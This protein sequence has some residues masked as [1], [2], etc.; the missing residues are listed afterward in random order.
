ML[1]KFILIVY[2]GFATS[3]LSVTLTKADIAK[4]LRDWVAKHLGPETLLSC[5]FC[6]GWWVAMPLTLIYQPMMTDK[7]FLIELFVSLTAIIGI[8]AVISGIIIQT[9]P[10][11]KEKR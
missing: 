5:P 7:Y 3:A 8:A 11:F 2:L 10:N 4:P 1:E 9:I 6:T